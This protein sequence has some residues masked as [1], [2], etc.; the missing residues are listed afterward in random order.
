[1]PPAVVQ[2]IREVAEITGVPAEHILSA[3]RD[4]RTHQ[5]RAAAMCFVRML[6]FPSGPP[7][8]P[9]IGKWFGGRDHTTV[10]SAIGRVGP[11]YKKPVDILLC[12]HDEEL[13]NDN[14]AA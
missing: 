6:R 13:A 4:R 14:I 2:I 7:S 5:A 12:A 10:M 9:Q 8:Y 1:M 3:R 11:K